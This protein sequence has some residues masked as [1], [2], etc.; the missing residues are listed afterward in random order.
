[1]TVPRW[2]RRLLLVTAGVGVGL[3]AAEAAARART[4]EAAAELLFSA[5]DAMPQD[6]YEDDPDLI[7]V[8]RPHFDSTVATFDYSVRVRI[9]SVGFIFESPEVG[10][11]LW[12]LSR[13]NDG[14]FVGMSKP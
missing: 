4:P 2:L 7:Q 13:D 5:P 3:I 10:A 9:N 8:S 12:A 1:M 14:S 11:F 6:M